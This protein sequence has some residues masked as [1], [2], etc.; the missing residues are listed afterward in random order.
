[1]KCTGPGANVVLSWQHRENPGMTLLKLP[2]QCW[3][4]LFFTL[5]LFLGKFSYCVANC[6]GISRFVDPNLQSTWRLFDLEYAEDLTHGDDSMCKHGNNQTGWDH[7]TGDEEWI[8]YWKKSRQEEKGT[9]VEFQEG[10]LSTAALRLLRTCSSQ[11]G[12]DDSSKQQEMPFA[13]VPFSW[14]MLDLFKD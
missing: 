5:F 2:L 14:K 9:G 13:Q 1:M 4:L 12:E 7:M 11:V 6:H 10:L 8:D 3:I